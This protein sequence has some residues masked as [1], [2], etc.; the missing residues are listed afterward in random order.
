MLQLHME[1]KQRRNEHFFHRLLL[2][3]ST[4]DGQGWRGV[5]RRPG[6]EEYRAINNDTIYRRPPGN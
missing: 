4:C 2:L 3:A 1:S 5:W 6:G